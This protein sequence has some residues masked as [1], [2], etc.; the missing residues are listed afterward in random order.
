MA[1]LADLYAEIDAHP[2]TV[3]RTEG[4]NFTTYI[5]NRI[6]YVVD[7]IE[8]EAVEINIVIHIKDPGPGEEAYYRP[9][10]PYLKSTTFRDRLVTEIA[11]FQAGT[12][13]LEEY[14]FVFVSEE[15]NYGIIKVYWDNAGSTEQRH[16]F[17][18]E[19]GASDIQ[20]RQIT[21]YT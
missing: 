2:L 4:D 14:D 18:W 12:P 5:F 7:Q 10:P 8:N 9:K 13:A 19:D 15:F 21:N 17:L 16:Y 11:T 3:E 1:T 6:I 20:F